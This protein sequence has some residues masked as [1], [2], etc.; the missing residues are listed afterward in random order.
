MNRL[1]LFLSIMLLSGVGVVYSFSIREVAPSYSPVIVERSVFEKSIKSMPAQDIVQVGKIYV[2]D[3]LLFIID[4][5]KGVH[6][7]Q[8]ANPKNPE[9]LSFL[10][11]LGCTNMAIKG[12]VMYAT[13]AEDIVA[14]DITDIHNI[15]EISRKREVL[16]EISSP[17]RYWEYQFSKESRPAN[18]VIIDWKLIKR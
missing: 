16:P 13:C 10:R 15:K 2:K 4:T 5:Y 12:S 17:Q 1:Y 3:S 8:N 7:V 11:I 18:T 9:K 6:V 14:I